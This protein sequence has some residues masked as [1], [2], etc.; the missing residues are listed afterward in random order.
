MIIKP[1]CPQCGQVITVDVKTIDN[2]QAEIKQLRA[3]L[4]AIADKSRNSSEVADY[5]MGLFK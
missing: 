2:L 1:V 3:R 5:L 4:Q